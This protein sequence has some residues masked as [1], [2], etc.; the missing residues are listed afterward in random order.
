MKMEELIYKIAPITR[1][2]KNKEIYVIGGALRDTLLKKQFKDLDFAT[3]L[4]TE[5]IEALLRSAGMPVWNPNKEPKVLGT[6]LCDINIEISSYEGKTIEA[7]LENRD[8]TINAMATTDGNIIDPYNGQEDIN[9]QIVKCVKSPQDC[10]SKDPLR[11]LRAIRFVSVLEFRLEDMTKNVIETYAHSI[12]TTSKDRWLKELTELLLGKNV[13]TALELL[14][15]TRLLGYLLPELY[16][17]TM[18]PRNQTSPTKDLWH[19]TKVVVSKSKP[20][21]IIRWAALL[22]DIAKPQTMMELSNNTHFFQHEYLGSELAG[23]TFDRLRV[24]SD[25]K[26]AVK[27]LISLHQRIGD[28]VSRRNDP[29]VSIN[30]FRRLIRD[31]NKH[32]CNIE[33]LIELFA[34]DCSSGKK[35]IVIR[36]EEH[37]NLLYKA[38][39]ET[40]EEDLRPRLPKGIGEALMKHFNLKPG[41][42]VGRIKKKLDDMLLT[43]EITTQTSFDQM[44]KMLEEQ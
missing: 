28:V 23:S 37:T 39:K 26:S 4:S 25:I 9:K 42:E 19:H 32:K 17:I 21:P 30:A 7:D 12:L 16:P 5:K 13:K 6:K 34:A 24:G 43:G 22:H 27:G 20:T 11:M 18:T 31:C 8:F 2:F 14:F 38:L 33:D 1:L 3:S 44:F 36:Q 10:F 15:K 29:P 35:E 40:R 41:S